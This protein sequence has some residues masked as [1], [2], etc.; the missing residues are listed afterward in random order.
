MSS[1]GLGLFAIMFSTFVCAS[2]SYNE[3]PGKPK[4]SRY[5]GGV[6]ISGGAKGKSLVSSWGKEVEEGSFKE[7]NKGYKGTIPSW[8]EPSPEAIAQ[9]K[10]F[11]EQFERF[12]K[13][14]KAK[15]EQARL[16]AWREEKFQNSFEGRRTQAE[17]NYWNG[18]LFPEKA[19]MK[20]L[21]QKATNIA[22]NINWEEVAGV[23]KQINDN[24]TMFR[25]VQSDKAPRDEQYYQKIRDVKSREEEL[26]KRIY[27]MIGAKIKTVEDSL[28]D[29]RERELFLA[30][31]DEEASKAVSKEVS[32]EVTKE[33]SKQLP[34]A[35]VAVVKSLIENFKN[36]EKD[37]VFMEGGTSSADLNI[38]Y[39]YRG[40]VGLKINV[41]KSKVDKR[42]DSID[43]S[44]VN[45]SRLDELYKERIEFLESLLKSGKRA[46]NWQLSKDNSRAQDILSELKKLDEGIRSLNVS[47]AEKTK[48]AE[49]IAEKVKKNDKQ[50]YQLMRKAIEQNL[51]PGYRQ[52]PLNSMDETMSRS[53]DDDIVCVCDNPK[54]FA[55]KVSSGIPASVSCEN[56]GR[57]VGVEVN[58]RI[59]SSNPA[60]KDKTARAVSFDE[61]NA[62]KQRFQRNK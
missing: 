16:K 37:G 23:L 44:A 28:R 60:A 53:S 59:S 33:E 36:G 57:L 61:A 52:L 42:I 58:G 11:Q 51:V 43:T 24:I 21:W 45:T 26:N 46:T 29:E 7:L 25:F 15:E 3:A 40:G 1:I 34:N 48:I 31:Y 50:L 38:G 8:G 2:N 17:R 35:F 13:E 6:N 19:K 49:D 56:C 30:Y 41:E 4:E 39:F 20:E 55:V 10:Y 5:P 27:E 22:Q 18:E 54:P 32:E 47:D 9:R 62:I 14:Q 12:E